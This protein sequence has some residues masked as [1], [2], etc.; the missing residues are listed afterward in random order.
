MTDSQENYQLDLGSEMAKT[1]FKRGT[2]RA[3]KFAQPNSFSSVRDEIK[4]HSN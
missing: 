1:K 2:F 4:V 3:F